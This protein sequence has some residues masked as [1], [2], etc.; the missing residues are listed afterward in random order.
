MQINELEK[1][2]TIKGK[3]ASK[4]FEMVVADFLGNRKDE[5]SDTF[6][7]MPPGFFP[8]NQAL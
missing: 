6:S 2:L 3:N 5:T 4:S 1:L 7:S 8:E